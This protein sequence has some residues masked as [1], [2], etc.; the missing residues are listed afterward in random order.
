[1]G[2]HGA[3]LVHLPEQMRRSEPNGGDGSPAVVVAR[4]VAIFIE[5]GGDALVAEEAARVLGGRLIRQAGVEELGEMV[6]EDGVGLSPVVLVDL[7]LGLPHG[8][9]LDTKPGDRGRPFGKLI[10]P[11]FFV[12]PK[13]WFSQRTRCPSTVIV[14]RSR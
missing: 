5:E 11:G 1:M 12:G 8:H 3:A 2:E 10:R 14:A 9:E 7:G 4:A 6:R 13:L